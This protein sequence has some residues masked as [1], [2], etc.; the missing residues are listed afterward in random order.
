MRIIAC[1]PSSLTI[2][3][4]SQS[5]G[6]LGHRAQS[7]DGALTVMR[8]PTYF[9]LFRTVG[10]KRLISSFMIVFG[11]LWL[12]IEPAALFFPGNLELGW[13]GYFVL[14][15]GSLVGAI[16]LRLPPKEISEALSSPDSLIKI[17]VGNLFDE[18]GHLVIGTNDV[19]DTELGNIIKP[20][21]VQG[22]FLMRIYKSDRARL[23]TDIEAALESHS[24]EKREDPNKAL[25]KR[26]RYPIGTTIALGASDSR[27]FLTAYGRMENGKKLKCTSDADSIWLSLSRLWEKVRLKGQSGQI[28]IPIIGSDLARTGLP[29]MALVKMIIISFIVASKEQF[30]TR[31]LT[32]VVCPEDLNSVNFYHLREFLAST[33]F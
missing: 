25:G 31:Q 5:T 22:Q 9:K 7:A 2:H 19:F 12:L 23:D 30:V 33:C 4:A 29:R 21:S 10:F 11:F 28:A 8:T 20:S 27:Y 13:L 24:H 32:V 17:K 15:I 26:W 6:I 16:I 18:P 1:K 14:V 3:K